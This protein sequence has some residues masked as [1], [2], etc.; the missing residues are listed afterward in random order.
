MLFFL[1][2]EINKQITYLQVTDDISLYFIHNTIIYLEPK[3]TYSA[4]ILFKFYK[5]KIL[6]ICTTQSSCVGRARFQ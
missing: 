3:Q 4:L 6:G 1:Q 5:I 2:R